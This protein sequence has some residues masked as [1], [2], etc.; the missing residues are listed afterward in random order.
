MSEVNTALEAAAENTTVA[1]EEME[2]AAETSTTE[3]AVETVE[4][5]EK[6]KGKDINDIIKMHMEAEKLI[7]KKQPEAPEEY[8]FPDETPEDFKELIN[9]V[10]KNNK[11]T[12][13]QAKALVDALIEN[14]RAVEESAKF[15]AEEALKNANKE[16]E[17]EFGS[18]LN[19]RLDAVKSILTKYGDVDTIEGL[20]N[21]GLLHDV[22]FVKFLDKITTDVLRHTVVASDF[23]E[24]S[25]LT[26]AEARAKIEEKK[27]SKEFM[28]A[29][30]DSKSPGHNEAVREWSTLFKAAYS[31]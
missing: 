17:K 14:N 12:Q 15:K 16:L 11:I 27:A 30:L 31:N 19:S 10:G 22:K 24:K 8:L 7:G 3:T 4:V 21:S 29:Y 20:K 6:Y 1:T 25:V 5:P 26:P 9:K 18:A 23:T 2:A 13:D 28:S